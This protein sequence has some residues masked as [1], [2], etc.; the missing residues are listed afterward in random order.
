MKTR[1]KLRSVALATAALG[2]VAGVA[3]AQPQQYRTPQSDRTPDLNRPGQQAQQDR[4]DADRPGQ[5]RSRMEARGEQGVERFLA[6]CWLAKNQAEIEISQLAQ[7]QARDPQVK[8]FAQMMVQD[9]RQLSQKLEPLAERQ[10]R[11]GRQGDTQA[12]SG[13]SDATRQTRGQGGPIN[14]LISI[15][16]QICEKQA[17]TFQQKLSQKSGPEFDQCYLAGQ[18]A[19]HMEAAAAL[20]VIS[21][22]TTGQLQQ[23][24]KQSKS[25]IDQHLQKAEQLF[26]Q[27]AK[28]STSRQASALSDRNVRPASAT[29]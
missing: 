2:L 12:R 25:K 23:L 29:E 26:E 8:Q 15:E 20:D 1:L 21:Q 16:K 18:I 11:Q 5:L 22:Q 7:S 13:Q 24:A 17:Q 19:C 4:Y 9:H 27:V 10:G 14:Q 6:S 3:M 28:S